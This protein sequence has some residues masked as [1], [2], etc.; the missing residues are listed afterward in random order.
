M[1]CEFCDQL[2]NAALPGAVAGVLLGLGILMA[3]LFIAA[4]YVYTALAWMTIARKLKHKRPWLAW[5][6]I[7]NISLILQLGKFHWAWVFLILI[8]VAGWIALFILSI[9]AT[10]RIFE[11]RKYPGWFSLAPLVPKIGGLLYLIAIGF[12]AWA[13]KKKR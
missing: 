12:V 7:V 8:P 6:P 9:I 11:K 13:D 10:W 1:V 2:S 4:F 5:I 3:L